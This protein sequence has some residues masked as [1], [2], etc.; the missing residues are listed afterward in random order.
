MTKWAGLIYSV[1]F[2]VLHTYA[3][4]CD[5]H[6]S[7]YV[8]TPNENNETKKRSFLSLRSTDWTGCILFFFFFFQINI[9][10]CDTVQT[11]IIGK[12]KCPPPHTV[13]Y[14]F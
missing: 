6:T 2:Y 10:L 7:Q 1:Y 13:I 4:R 3:Y 12:A 14:H 11:M 8:L 9:V 5:V